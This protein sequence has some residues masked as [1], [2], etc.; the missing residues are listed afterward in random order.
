M[1][2]TG[3]R[4]RRIVQHVLAKGKIGLKRGAALAFPTQSDRR[5]IAK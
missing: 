3:R 1:Q 2:G 5:G 4:K